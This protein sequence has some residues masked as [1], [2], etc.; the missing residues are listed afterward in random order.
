[1]T[2]KREAAFHEAGHAVAA[3]LSKFHR[4]VGSINL[5]QYGAGAINVSLSKSKLLAAG[6]TVDQSILTDKDVAIDIAVVLSAGFVCEQL[7]EQR[8]VGLSA[9]ASCAIPDHT[10]M[11][12][13]L[14]QAGLSKNFDQHELAAT[15]LLEQHWS[16]VS[17]LANHLFS[18]VSID[19]VDLDSFLEEQLRG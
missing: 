13:Q 17:K 1:M 16:V 7:A 11:Q 14:A 3:H 19:P 5:G 18:C 6:K 15:Q 8:E 2:I 12:R 10:L 9:N 4:I